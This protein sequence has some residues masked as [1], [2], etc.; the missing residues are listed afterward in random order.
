M[1]AN[2]QDGRER[3]CGCSLDARL[4]P[5]WNFYMCLGPIKRDEGDD[6]GPSLVVVNQGFLNII[7]GVTK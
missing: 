6:V 2:Q 3:D 5:I 7:R 4:R 1:Y